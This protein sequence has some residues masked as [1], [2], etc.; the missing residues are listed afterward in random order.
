[1]TTD[2]DKQWRIDN[3]RL[4]K[5]VRLQFR[6]YTRWNETWDHDHCAACWATFA[7]Y[8]GPDFQHEGYATCDDYPRGACYDW[9][10]QSCFADLK[11][12][13]GWT[14]VAST[15]AASNPMKSLLP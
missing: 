6:R 9:I 15:S 11:E 8:D 7:E 14:V 10:C 1:M 3:A 4:L 2:P 12:D 5:G 13:M